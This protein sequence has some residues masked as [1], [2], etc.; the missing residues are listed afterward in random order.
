MAERFEHSGCPTIVIN[1]GTIRAST[2]ESAA[3][4]SSAIPS[5]RVQTP[6]QAPFISTPESRNGSS[7]A[8][9]VYQQQEQ[10]KYFTP[11]E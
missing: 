8:V 1:A 4:V 2:P 6:A 5:L 3:Q 9:S 10:Q 11:G 7:S